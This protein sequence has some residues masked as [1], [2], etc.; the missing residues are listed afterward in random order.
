MFATSVTEFDYETTLRECAARRVEALHR[1]YEHEADRLLGVAL[2]IV[3]HRDLAE[4]ILHEAF[5][6]IWRMAHTFDSARGSGRAWLSTIVRNRALNVLRAGRRTQPIDDGALDAIPDC[7]EKPDETLERID[8]E[9]RLKRCLQN[10]DDMK[11]TS[12]LLAYVDGL[13]QSEIAERLGTSHNTVKSW[14]R[15]GLL[16]L[17]ECLQ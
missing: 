2:R 5:I 12:I 10:L 17:R 7:A 11:R 3:R 14:V 9:V 15:R 1:L 8:D 16:A 13:S 6:Q 4:D